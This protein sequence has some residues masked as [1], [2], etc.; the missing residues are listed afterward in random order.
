MIRKRKG[1]YRVLSEDGKKNL[2]GP[3]NYNKEGGSTKTASPHGIF[4]ASDSREDIELP[5]GAP[6][7][8]ILRRKQESCICSGDFHIS[9]E[10]HNSISLKIITRHLTPFKFLI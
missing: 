7:C 5:Q 6:G 8:E 2:G 1:G 10:F 3:Y 9:F 4:Q